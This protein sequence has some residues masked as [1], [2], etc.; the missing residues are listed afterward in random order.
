LQSRGG[1][2]PSIRSSA[3]VYSPD[4]A[5]TE[6]SFA[7]FL[8]K[9]K[10][11]CYNSHI[12][13]LKR[14]RERT[15]KQILR[16]LALILALVCVLS[17][18]NQSPSPSVE[19]T[20]T[21]LDETT[22][23]EITPEVTTPE[24]TTPEV[25][26]PE[27][28]TPEVTT[29][30][31]TTPEE[32]EESFAPSVGLAYTVNDDGETCTIT[33]IGTCTDTNIYIDDYIDGYKVT[34]IGELA[35]YGCSALTSV[36]VGESV[37]SIEAY[38][39]CGCY[40]LTSVTIGDSITSIGSCAFYGCYSLT[41]VVIPDSV[42][43]ISYAAF[44]GCNALTSVTIP[45]S[46]T[47][48]GDHAFEGCT[49]LTSVTIPDS[50]TSIGYTAFYGCSR[51]AS[52][53][54]PESVTSIGDSAFDGCTSLTS[55]IFANPNGWWC[56]KDKNATSGTDISVADLSDSAIAADYLKSTYYDYFWYRTE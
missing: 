24:V 48:I 36:T 35:F 5:R 45:D 29:P 44:F 14:E 26:T 11:V 47:S 53:T 23:E 32:P 50:V 38:A 25:T 49:A 10:K 15:M 6:S 20:S 8:Y 56:T 4:F 17:S 3:F 43:S 41:S 39:F 52:V 16:T 13:T 27:V 1:L 21:T 31:E 46:V 30:E 54:I 28:T 22:P 2:P 55:V 34:A 12:Q 18:C 19:T 40:S 7:V 9:R 37:T 33:G 51:L 42:T